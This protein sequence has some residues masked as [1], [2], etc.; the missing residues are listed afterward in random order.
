MRDDGAPGEGAA[1]RVERRAGR[2]GEQAV[3]QEAGGGFR[4]AGGVGELDGDAG[5]DGA[6]GNGGEGW[7]GVRETAAHSAHPIARC[8][9]GLAGDAG[10]EFVKPRV[11]GA[12]VLRGGGPVARGLGVGEI[13][14]VDGRTDERLVVKRLEFL[15][16]RQAP[17]LEA[18]ERELLGVVKRVGPI[19][20]GADLGLLPRQPGVGVGNRAVAVVDQVMDRTVGR[21]SRCAAHGANAIVQRAAGADRLSDG[22]R[23]DTATGIGAPLVGAV[24]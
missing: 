22:L 20:R 18:A 8:L 13:V 16:V 4:V 5:V 19:G 12:V 24:A 9:R 17:V 7:R 15:D 23:A 10:D 11:A 21:G 2:R 3:G 1:G 6:I 14:R